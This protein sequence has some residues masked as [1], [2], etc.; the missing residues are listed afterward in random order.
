MNR[1][2]DGGG[3]GKGKGKKGGTKGF[4][5]KKKGK[6]SKGFG[7]KGKGKKGKNYEPYRVAKFVPKER[8]TEKGEYKGFFDE[9]E[10]WHDLVEKNGL[11]ASSYRNSK[12]ERIEDDASVLDENWNNLTNERDEEPEDESDD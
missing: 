11:L 7:K 9:N 6:K 4:F 3:K 5:G 2:R 1:F 12:G 8:K 10:I